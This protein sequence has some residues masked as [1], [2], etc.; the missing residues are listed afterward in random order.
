MDYDATEIAA[1][2]DKARALA[3]ETLRLWQDLLSVD[4]DRAAISLVIDLGFGT[5]R[6]SKLLAAQFGVQVIGI[7]P[8]QKMLDQA[9]NKLAAGNV[10]YRQAAAE[11]I[12]LPNGCADLVFMSMVYHHL[13][14]PAAVALECRRVL[15]QAGYV[16][17]RNGTRESDF[18][19]RHFFPALRARID[20]DLPSRRGVEAVF[21]EGGLT[22]IVHRVVTQ[23][24]AP[25]WPSFIEKSAL[26]ADS[27]LARLSDDDFQR[28]MA[29]LRTPGDA[30]NQND[31]VTEEIDWFVFLRHGIIDTA[32]RP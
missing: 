16:C 29:A 12:P 28:G 15:R 11:A 22:P 24:T 25:D 18:P 32:W 10:V 19:H 21:A 1:S 13:T 3:P 30:I 6:F 2:Y 14:D 26:R 20:S 8:S 4:I 9:R 5:G 17:V 23:V 31:A 7:D 27:F